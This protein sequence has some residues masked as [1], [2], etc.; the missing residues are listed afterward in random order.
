[1]ATNI[2]S[3]KTYNGQEASP[4]YT[5]TVSSVSNIDIAA[6]LTTGSTGQLKYTIQRKTA[7]SDWR[8]AVDEHNQV[9]SFSTFGDVDNGINIAGLNAYAIRVKVE[10]IS[11]AGTLNIEYESI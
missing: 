7:N 8:D 11:G 5:S 4:T 10:I 2:L 3:A 1:M 9:L 6:I